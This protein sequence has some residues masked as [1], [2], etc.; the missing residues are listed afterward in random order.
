ML[1]ECGE[2]VDRGWRVCWTL[3]GGRAQILVH[4]LTFVIIKI[5]RGCT[6]NGCPTRVH[7]HKDFHLKA[8]ARIWP[9]LSCLCQIYLTASVSNTP[10][11]TASTTSWYKR[12]KVVIKDH[13]KTGARSDALKHP[14]TNIE[15]PW[16]KQSASAV[17]GGQVS[18]VRIVESCSFFIS[19]TILTP[20]VWDLTSHVQR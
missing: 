5:Q 14:G 7:L 6:L 2:R 19:S 8:K 18:W 1:K 16:C 20:Y 15:T 13:F 4:A 10:R 9:W 11:G 17:Q 3:S 12:I